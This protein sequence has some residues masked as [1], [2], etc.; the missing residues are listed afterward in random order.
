MNLRDLFMKAHQF[1]TSPTTM[2]AISDIP[3]S[4]G[5]SAFAV[6]PEANDIVNSARKMSS[7]TPSASNLSKV[8]NPIL[9]TVDNMNWFW[10]NADLNTLAGMSKLL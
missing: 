7:W 5:T 4:G 1:S 6:L 3:K 9:D 8:G 10:R 2:R